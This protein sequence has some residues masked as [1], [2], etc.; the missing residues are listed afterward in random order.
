LS[1]PIADCLGDKF[2]AIVA[3]NVLRQ[4]VKRD[5]LFNDPDRIGGAN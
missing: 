3:A 1:H 2:W 5:G 4:A